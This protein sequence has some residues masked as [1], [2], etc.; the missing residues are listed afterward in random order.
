MSI[1]AEIDATVDAFVKDLAALV[2]RVAEES[3]REALGELGHSPP[4]GQRAPT[5]GRSRPARAPK[6]AP[7]HQ[8]PVA[9]S[10]EPA[11]ATSGT[12]PTTTSRPVVPVP[13]KVAPAA[14][15]PPAVP[16]T[17]VPVRRIPPKRRRAAKAT[18][19]AP[20]PVEASTSEPVPARAWVVVRRSAR[21]R[22][23]AAPGA[24]AT[25]GEPSPAQAAAQSGE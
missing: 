12:N 23:D 1:G 25:A 22:P 17:A 10:A 2:R 18:P 16:A 20:P 9:G 7:A 24:E 8:K 3:L 6:G 13:P 21:A 19:P 5:R 15:S 4:T 11:A 14:A